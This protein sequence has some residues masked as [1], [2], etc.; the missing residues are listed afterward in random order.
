MENST[1]S[2]RLSRLIPADTT[3]PENVG[4]LFQVEQQIRRARLPDGHGEGYRG[5]S[6]ERRGFGQEDV[7]LFAE[8]LGKS[9]ETKVCLRAVE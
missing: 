4:E 6:R 8:W 9:I 2:R 3:D 1:A 7:S 5:G